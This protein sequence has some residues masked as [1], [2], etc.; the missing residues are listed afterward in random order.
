M[1][2]VVGVRLLLLEEDVEGETEPEPVD[3]HPMQQDGQDLDLRLPPADVPV[4]LQHRRVGA[5]RVAHDADGVLG[6]GGQHDHAH[7]A[8]LLQERR[9]GAVVNGVPPRVP[10]DVHFQVRHLL[11]KGGPGGTG[12]AR[13]GAPRADHTRG[14]R[15]H[16]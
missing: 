6:V 13:Q 3:H 12:G 9:E 15:R 2:V 10:P 14:I 11:R 8:V 7:V 1:N 16:R 4:V 5:G